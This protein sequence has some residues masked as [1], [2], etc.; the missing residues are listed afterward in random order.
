MRVKPQMPITPTTSS[1]AVLVVRDLSCHV[2]GQPL[3]Y[4][5][6]VG[7][8]RAEQDS[9]QP[10]SPGTTGAVG[11]QHP[12]FENAAPSTLLG[13]RHLADPDAVRKVS[14]DEGPYASLGLG[15][16]EIAHVVVQQTVTWK[17]D[18]SS[19]FIRQLTPE[20]L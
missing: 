14:V 7:H 17:H 1:P 15:T 12:L 18:S 6:G 13:A 11:D 20:A 16:A 3:V 5:A 9:H 2:S 4:P 19:A 8:E 10:G